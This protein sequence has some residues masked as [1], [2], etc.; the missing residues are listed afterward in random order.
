MG[1]RSGTCSRRDWKSLRVDELIR[2][3]AWIN[4]MNG[5]VWYGKIDRIEYLVN[6]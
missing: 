5:L 2:V 1:Q 4:K 3:K 6:L